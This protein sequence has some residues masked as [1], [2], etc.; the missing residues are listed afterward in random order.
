VKPTI[1]KNHNVLKQDN[2]NWSADT[3][4]NDIIKSYKCGKPLLSAL[5]E[6]IAKWTIAEECYKGK[7]YKY[8]IGGEA[9]DWK[10]LVHRIIDQLRPQID[11]SVDISAFNLN[12]TSMSD[13]LKRL[14]G[15][16]KYRALLNYYYGV[17]VENA[18]L[19]VAEKEV[20]KMRLGKGYQSQENLQEDAFLRVYQ[21]SR[22]VLLTKFREQNNLAKDSVLNQFDKKGFTYWLFK[23]RLNSSDRAKLA[24][25]TKKGLDYLNRC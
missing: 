6:Q 19:Q 18:I 17:I 22:S 12:V 4:I 2:L 16:E 9:F 10:L 25:D 1:C 24:S 8:L 21:S 5:L 20:R 15:H 7:Q 14:L 11:Q 3:V 23:Y 13:D